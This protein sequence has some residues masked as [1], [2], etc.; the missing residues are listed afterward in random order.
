MI[1]INSTITDPYF[2]LAAEEFM[3][4]HFTEDVFMVWQSEPSVIIGR[5]QDVQAEVNLALAEKH[6]IKIARRSSGGGAVY[7]DLGNVNLT[8]I[9]NSKEPDFGKFSTLMID[10]LST[11]GIEAKVD[12]RRGL[13][14]DGLKISGSAQSI[15]GG[16]ILFHASLL[17]STNLTMLTSVLEGDLNALSH[18]PETK[19]KSYV[20]SVK[21]QVT[22]IRRHMA[23]SMQIS[24]FKQ[25]L[26][27]NFLDREASNR[28]YT[29]SEKERMEIA[30][31][32]E[33]K[34]STPNWNLWQSRPTNTYSVNFKT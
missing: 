33:E 15:F 1:C 24:D 7:D 6:E 11:L 10:F 8:F 28:L 27:K 2:N 5:H 30:R 23:Q 34:Y 32:R 13:T 3:L 22:N 16:R 18:I 14:V 25:L 29:F 19:R 17:F 31:L 12:E 4:K 26:I 21:S 20:K 9:E